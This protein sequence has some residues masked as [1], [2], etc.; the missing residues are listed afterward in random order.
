MDAVTAPF[1]QWGEIKRANEGT[2]KITR[3]DPSNISCGYISP[4]NVAQGHLEL[5]VHAD[6]SS[7][8]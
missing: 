2:T 8:G 5:D 3:S 1:D 4:E 6:G 7:T